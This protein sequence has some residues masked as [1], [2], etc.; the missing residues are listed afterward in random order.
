MRTITGPLDASELRRITAHGDNDIR[1]HPG[2][3]FFEQR[4]HG[5]FETL[6]FLALDILGAQS[7]YV[8]TA[9]AFRHSRS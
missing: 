8:G 4:R 7:T 6:R 3:P 1:R 2:Y 9:V 5:S